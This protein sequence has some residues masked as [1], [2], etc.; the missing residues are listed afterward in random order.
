MVQTFWKRGGSREDHKSPTLTAVSRHGFLAYVEL[1]LLK[2]AFERSG[3]LH[4]MYIYFS[5]VH[6]FFPLILFLDFLG[7]LGCGARSCISQSTILSFR[8]ARY[9]RWRLQEGKNR[10]KE[11]QDGRGNGRP[12]L[13]RPCGSY[14]PRSHVPPGRTSACSVKQCISQVDPFEKLPRRQ[15]RGHDDAA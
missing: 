3:L 12:Y 4:L 13:W 9:I 15:C 14:R 5:A 6:C 1:D 11:A 8:R 2:L 7:T 10:N